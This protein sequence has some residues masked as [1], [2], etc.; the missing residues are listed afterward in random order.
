MISEVEIKKMAKELNIPRWIAQRVLNEANN[1]P[2]AA[3]E[4]LIKNTL[5]KEDEKK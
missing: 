5:R 1:D 2:N 4:L 3:R